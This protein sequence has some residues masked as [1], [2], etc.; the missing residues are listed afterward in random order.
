MFDSSIPYELYIRSGGDRKA[1]LRFPTDAE[2]IERTRKMRP[3][4]RDLGRSRSQFDVPNLTDVNADLFTLLRNPDDTE[5]VEKEDASAFIGK[6]LRAD[7]VDSYRAGDQFV[8]D[9]VVA[10]GHQVRH[11]LRMPTQRDLLDYGRQSVRTIDSRRTH[12]MRFS[13]EPA[14][15]L[16]D[17]LQVST[18]GYKNG[19]VPIVHKDAA[20]LEVMALMEVEDA[21]P[22][23]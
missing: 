11:T 22:E 8:V 20:L 2:L 6:L 21:D 15:A 7:V 12:D 19:S 9:L 16:W 17:K 13:L 4:R 3:V 10:A 18:E 5:A 14:G 23:I 1:R